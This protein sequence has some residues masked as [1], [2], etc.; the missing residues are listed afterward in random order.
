MKDKKFPTIFGI[1]LLLV[2]LFIGVFLSTKKTSLSSKASVSCE[3]INPQIANLTYGSF[4]F[5]FTTPSPCGATLNINN[6]IYQDASLSETTHYFKISNLFPK[7][8]YKFSLIS[9]SNTY[10]YPEYALTTATKPNSSIPSSNLAWGKI[11]DS[12]GKPVPGAIIYLTLPGSQALSAFSNK[13]GNW[14]ISFASS[15]NEQKTDWFSPASVVEEEII[16][17]SPDSQLT[18]VSNK[19]NQNDPVPDIIIGQDYLSVIPTP[20]SSFQSSLNSSQIETSLAKLSITSPKENETIYTL[21]PDI[22]GQG[23]ASNTFQLDIDGNKENITVSPS[24]IWNYSPS[25]NLSPGSHL[26]TL[27]FQ[28]EIISRNFVVAQTNDYLSF[29]ATPSATLIPT[30]VVIPT[31]FASPTPIIQPTLVP[32]I[33]TAKPS[34]TST[35]YESG[36]SLPTY[37]IS[38]LSIL[39]FGVSFYYSH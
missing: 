21:K 4:D 10:S 16:V 20:P 32:T 31:I 12:S 34:T 8:D 30:Q 38:I 24:N 9:G 29:T 6:I 33:R 27:N 26:L 25:Q 23:P 39:F 37:L 11:I 13:D 2:I 15:F 22:F 14:N 17:Y 19:S 1:I 35:L 5:S 7:T 18:Q 3:P 28:G 36:N